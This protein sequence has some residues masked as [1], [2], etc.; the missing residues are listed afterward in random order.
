[1]ITQAVPE[2]ESAPDVFYMDM[3]GVPW[4][5]S[6]GVSL[7]RAWD[8][9]GMTA[10]QSHAMNFNDMPATRVAWP[11]NN[12]RQRARALAGRPA[13]HLFTSVIVGVVEEA[14]EMARQQVQRKKD[15]MRP[16]RAGGVVEGGD[17]GLAD[18]ASL[19][20]CASGC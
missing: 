20:R 3:R 18:S 1:M 17:G 9:H 14:V 19:R 11:D 15:S 7:A 8:G 13:G 2:G 6:A 10:T 5:G 12:E 16:V 4:D